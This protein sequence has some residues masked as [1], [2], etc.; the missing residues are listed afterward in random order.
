[1]Q[2]YVVMI[3]DNTIEGNLTVTWQMNIEAFEAGPYMGTQA[4]LHGRG[5]TA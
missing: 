1:M 3:S 5:G 2:V 4:V